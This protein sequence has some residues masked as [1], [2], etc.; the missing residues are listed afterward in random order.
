MKIKKIFLLLLTFFIFSN[1]KINALEME[2]D[3]VKPVITEDKKSE[4]KLV[5]KPIV[6]EKKE[7]KRTS[8]DFVKDSKVIDEKNE[9]INSTITNG[10]NLPKLP[11]NLEPTKKT[12][13]TISLKSSVD[14]N[15]NKVVPKEKIQFL[16]IETKNGIKFNIIIDYTKSNKNVKFLTESTETDMLNIISQKEKIE[17]EKKKQEEEKI[18][19]EKE[20]E[21]EAEDKKLLEEKT[22]K[23]KSKSKKI[24]II[25]LII[26]SIVLVVLGIVGKVFYPKFKDKISNK[27]RF[28]EGD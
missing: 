8:L 15:G 18:K 27:N 19:E 10:S 24:T 2:L 12:D 21:R 11:L 14:E 6:E 28:S 4:N 16:P 13:S 1:T 3:E 20:K 7:D 26:I 17:L 9:N 22:K 5:E 25:K 23:E